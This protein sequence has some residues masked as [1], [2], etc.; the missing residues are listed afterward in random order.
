MSQ[1]VAPLCN[2]VAKRTQHVTPNNVAI[3]YA[4]MLRTF[5]RGFQPWEHFGQLSQLHRQSS[6]NGEPVKILEIKRI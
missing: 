4:E 5:G 6:Q 2:R 3:C 1:D